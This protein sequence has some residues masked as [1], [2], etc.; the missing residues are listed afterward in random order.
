MGVIMTQYM[1]GPGLARFQKKGEETVTAKL[2]K[3]HNMQ[4]FVPV[5]RSSLLDKEHKQAVG[6]LLFLKKKQDS[7]YEGEW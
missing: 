1:I 3:L 5:H 4:T 6:S 7:P 2:R